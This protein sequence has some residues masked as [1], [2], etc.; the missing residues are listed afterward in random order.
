MG[1][2]PL[3]QWGLHRVPPGI[4]LSGLLPVEALRLDGQA[5]IL[6]DCGIER[7]DQLMA[8]PREAVA[9]RFDPQLL[10]RLNQAIGII[11]E[12]IASHRP[13][14]EIE[15][16]RQLEFPLSD[17]QALEHLV[18]ELLAG[19]AQ[20]LARRQQGALQIRCELTMRVDDDRV[21]GRIVSA[22]RESVAPSGTGGD[23]TGPHPPAGTD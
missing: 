2:G 9:E 13:P 5:E 7:I 17:R 8:L 20:E 19:V 16:E 4:R 22:Q 15:V 12:P 1:A 21:H 10:L 6:A 23:A 18:A 14:P 3:R 11:P